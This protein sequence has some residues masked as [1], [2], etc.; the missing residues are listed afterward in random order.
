MSS[1]HSLAPTFWTVDLS[2]VGGEPLNSVRDDT[3]VSL[4]LSLLGLDGACAGAVLA[5]NGNATLAT[6]NLV[7]YAERHE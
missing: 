6:E 1:T 5:R 7:G 4:R 3:H 2:G